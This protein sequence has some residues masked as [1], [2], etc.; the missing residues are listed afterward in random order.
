VTQDSNTTWVKEAE[1]RAT[2]MEGKAQ[3]RLLRVEKKSTMAR[4]YA[5]EEIESLVRKVALLEG[6]LAEVHR[7]HEVA[8]E[9]ACGLSDAA[10]DPERWQEESKRGRQEQLEELTLL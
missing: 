10:A 1:D 5:R 3:E 6:E 8:E 2:M 9:T 4:A 7:A